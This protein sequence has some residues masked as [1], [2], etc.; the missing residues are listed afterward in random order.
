MEV[1]P[2]VLKEIYDLDHT[3]KSEKYQ[4]I[5]DESAGLLVKIVEEHGEYF[6]STRFNKSEFLKSLSNILFSTYKKLELKFGKKEKE[7]LEFNKEILECHTTEDFL[8]II[9]NKKYHHCLYRIYD[10]LIILATDYGVD[11][12]YKPNTRYLLYCLN[13]RNPEIEKL[14]LMKQIAPNIKNN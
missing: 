2:T 13:E 1:V 10:D 11:Y 4:Y 3:I 6:P 9:A 7:L 12:E 5:N 8:K 14:I